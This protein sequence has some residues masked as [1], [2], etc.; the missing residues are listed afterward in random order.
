MPSVALSLFFLSGVATVFCPFD[1]L[2]KMSEES[3]NLLQQQRTAPL[4]SRK[5]DPKPHFEE[6]MG[7]ETAKTD[8]GIPKHDVV[9]R[10]CGR[11]SRCFASTKTSG[12]GR[13]SS[14]V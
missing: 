12:T 1:D 4:L 14:L 3:F 10:I 13:K 2:R 8:P 5:Q 11:R 9:I 7:E 6:Y